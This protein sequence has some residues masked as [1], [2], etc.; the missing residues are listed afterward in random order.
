MLRPNFPISILTLFLAH[1][2]LVTFSI[3]GLA[4]LEEFRLLLCEGGVIGLVRS[5]GHGPS[6]K[7]SKV[8]KSPTLP[9]RLFVCVVSSESACWLGSGLV[10]GQF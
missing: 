5:G 1:S 10:Y 2:M 8:L 9:P 7:S 4:L 3:L 6:V